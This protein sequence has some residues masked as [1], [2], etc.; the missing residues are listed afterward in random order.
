MIADL[1]LTP[2]K[3]IKDDRGQVMHM[4]RNDSPNFQ[5][6][7]EVY[8]STLNKGVVKGWKKHTEMVMNLTVVQG[9]IE[10]TFI[11]DR[12]SGK[13]TTQTVV[14]DTQDNYQLLTVPAGIWF[15]FKNLADG[16][17]MLCNCA[18]IAHRPEEAINISL[19]E[20]EVAKKLGVSV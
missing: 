13:P 8:F 5:N 19:D 3:I 16:P 9:Q 14:V 2:L 18:S 12:D 11:D 6:F 7:G 4:V 1:V 15:C 20:L 17:S 10:F